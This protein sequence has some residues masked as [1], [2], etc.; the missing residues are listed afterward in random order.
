MSKLWNKQKLLY[1]KK[2]CLVNIVNIIPI[3]VPKKT[4]PKEK[5]KSS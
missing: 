4:K 2:S 5:S 3:I 1:R